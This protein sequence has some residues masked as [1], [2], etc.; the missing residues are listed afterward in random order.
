MSSILKVAAQ[1]IS[2]YSM[3]E[4]ND[5][6]LSIMQILLRSGWENSF[7]GKLIKKVKSPF[8]ASPSIY[9]LETLKDGDLIVKDRGG[10]VLAKVDMKGP[11]SAPEIMNAARTLNNGVAKVMK[12]SEN[13]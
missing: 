5:A 6:Q 10:R 12:G 4:T 1:F 2:R 8:S 13:V 11:M 3:P 7:S 9:T